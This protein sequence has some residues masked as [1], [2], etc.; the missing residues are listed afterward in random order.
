MADNVWTPENDCWSL[1]QV[2]SFKVRSP[3]AVVS[4][5]C[6]C[7]CTVHALISIHD[8]H[9]SAAYTQFFPPGFSTTR[10][11]VKVQ[12]F[13]WSVQEERACQVQHTSD[14]S[15]L[16]L[17]AFVSQ[18]FVGL[19]PTLECV[20]SYLAGGIH[21]LAAGRPHPDAEEHPGSLRLCRF[22]A[23]SRGHQFC[24]CIWCWLALL[25]S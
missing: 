1:L 2:Y 16:R 6:L 21:L 23:G 3:A 10:R 8:S 24:L 5:A 18:L 17:L 22:T 19:L 14:L 15:L 12:M 11:C 9:P 25:L 7:R 4:Q 13:R 20:P